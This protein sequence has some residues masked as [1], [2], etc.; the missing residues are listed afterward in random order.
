MVTI[1]TKQHCPQCAATKRRLARNGV[2]FVEQDAISNLDSLKS[3]GFRAAPVVITSETKWSG[4]R[5]DLIDEIRVP[6][7][8]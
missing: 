4:Y 8:A 6:V 7:A 1:Y 2:Q 5:P 3:M